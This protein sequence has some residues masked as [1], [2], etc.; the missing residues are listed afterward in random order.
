LIRAAADSE[1]Q[2]MPPEIAKM[3]L[4]NDLTDEQYAWCL[5]RLVA[6]APG[7]T[8]EPVD[9]APLR[10]DMPRTWVRTLNDLIVSA[11]QQ[12]HY[13]ENVGHCPVVDLDAGH[14]CMVSRPAELAE[15]LNGVARP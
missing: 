10:S 9:L 8:T 7:L 6:E 13:V 1:P 12:L 4:G 3:V 5:E 2:P 14:M 15:I 11:E